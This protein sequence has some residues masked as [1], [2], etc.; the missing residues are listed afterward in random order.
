MMIDTPAGIQAFRLL[1]LRG[2]L[3]LEIKGLKFRIATCP[4]IKQEFGL[5]GNKQRVLE[6]FE[7]ILRE[8]GILSAA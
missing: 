7:V 1:S 2:R 4:I 5:K 8:R 3:Q 6:Q